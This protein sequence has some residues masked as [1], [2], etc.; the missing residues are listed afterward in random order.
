MTRTRIQCIAFSPCADG[1]EECKTCDELLVLCKAIVCSRRF[2]QL[3]QMQTWQS[4]ENNSDCVCVWACAR[5][6]L[7]AGSACHADDCMMIAFR[8]SLPL[9][10][11]SLCQNHLCYFMAEPYLT[12]YYYYYYYYSLI[13][14]GITRSKVILRTR[15]ALKDSL[16]TKPI[17]KHHI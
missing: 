9:L 8:L 17:R 13:M 11:H 6:L 1:S 10:T 5:V 14:V 3:R 16:K 4:T 12:V 7:L 2:E 15:L